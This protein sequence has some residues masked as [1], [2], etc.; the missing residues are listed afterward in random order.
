MYNER[1]RV[2]KLRIVL[3][4]AMLAAVPFTAP[5]LQR[6]PGNPVSFRG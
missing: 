4:F 2:G 3:A 1:A 6:G 5:L